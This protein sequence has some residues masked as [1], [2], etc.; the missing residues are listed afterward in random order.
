MK[1]II[2]GDVFAY[3]AAVMGDGTHTSDD[4]DFGEAKVSGDAPVTPVAVIRGMTAKVLRYPK[5]TSIICA[6]SSADGSNWRK[7]VHPHYKQS[8]G[9]KP[10][11]YD[12]MVAWLKK[13]LKT[14]QFPGLEGDDI[15]GLLLTGSSGHDYIGFSTDKDMRTLPARFV[16]MVRGGGYEPMIRPS[17]IEA[18]RVWMTQ[19]I[20]GDTTDEYKG[21]PGAGVKAAEKA[22]ADKTSLRSMWD[23]VLCLYADQFDHKKWGK[24]F[25]TKSAYDEALMNA[26]VARIL[27]SGDYNHQTGEVTLWTPNGDPMVIDAAGPVAQG[28]TQK[29]NSSEGTLVSSL[30][31]PTVSKEPPSMPP[32]TDQKTPHPGTSKK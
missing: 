14:Y 29:V 7:Q 20:T 19:T 1:A 32:T 11:A 31:T 30:E 2:D 9:E 25:V 4:I 22:L 28:S 27:R 18:D 3:T 6:L 26:R 16:R 15:M 13:N 10:E 23:A 8:R 21:A 24:Q 5:V 17:V 12:E